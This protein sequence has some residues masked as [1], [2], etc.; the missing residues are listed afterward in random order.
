MGSPPFHVPAVLTGTAVASITASLI[1]NSLIQG[2]ATG[3][4]TLCAQAYGSGNKH[5]VGLHM[6]RMVFFILPCVLPLMI[7]W[8]EADKILVHVLPERR[9]AELTGTYLR[10]LSFRIPASVFFECGKRFVQAQG[11]FS[12][13]TYVLL[14]TA[15]LNAFLTWFLVWRLDWG[16]V[17]A[18]TAVVITENLM[19][20]LLVLYIWL[21]DGSQCWGG[22]TTKAFSNWGTITSDL[23]W[24]RA[25]TASQGR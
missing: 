17:G 6:Q 11:I 13:A 9:L 16:F 25:L 10:I 3:L 2:L 4:D 7:L 21:V 15:P 18:P 20:V 1:G 23:T 24:T 5:L 22:F 12:A 8:W 14:I 19:A